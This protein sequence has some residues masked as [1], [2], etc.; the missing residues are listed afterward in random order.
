MQQLLDDTEY[1]NTVDNLERIHP[2][3]I[4]S[5]FNLFNGKPD[6]TT[7]IF[8][9]NVLITIADL[10]VLRDKMND[11]LAH[12]NICGSVQTL[13]VRF[14]NNKFQEFSDWFQFENF[15]WSSSNVIDSMI[16]KWDF[17]I[18]FS[19][20][21]VPQRHTVVVRLS[22]GLKPE[23]VLQMM[24]SGKIEDLDSIDKN[25]AP[26]MCS[27]SFVNQLIG[28][29]ILN[30]VEEW[31]KGLRLAKDINNRFKF[32]RKHRISTAKTIELVTKFAGVIIIASSLN[33]LLHKFNINTLAELTTFHLQI[34]II[35]IAFSY[36][37]FEIISRFSY[38]LAKNTLKALNQYGDIFTFNITKGDGERQELIKNE[39]EKYANNITKGIIFT[40]FINIICGV[41]A[42][43]ICNIILK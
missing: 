9:K 22:S 14:E 12:Y 4:K 40:V 42:T 19:S 28:E 37:F 31:D 15:N 23:Q 5:L 43:F 25:L 30:I 17:M 6:S 29:E 35:S 13:H 27:V 32:L 33:F 41:F 36:L 7:R 18:N 16:L 34:L 38:K 1:K 2:E 21:A 26:V 8:P 24:I 11:K 20:Y 10:L 3:E 39:N